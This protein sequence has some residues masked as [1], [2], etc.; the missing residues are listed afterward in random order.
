MNA[1]SQALQ[2]VI[3]HWWVDKTMLFA[4]GSNGYPSFF[5]HK[6]YKC[7]KG[8]SLK[9]LID[10]YFLFPIASQ[11]NLYLTIPIVSD[12]LGA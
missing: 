12:Q 3:A 9:A 10:V 8:I 6:I 11:Q 5:A 1:I 2:T 4:A 7:K